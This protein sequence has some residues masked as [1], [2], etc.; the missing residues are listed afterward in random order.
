VGTASAEKEPDT[1]NEQDT[2]A[3]HHPLPGFLDLYPQMLPIRD[4]VKLPR[5][6]AGRLRDYKPKLLR[7]E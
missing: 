6:I 3:W 2:P 4:G 5:V 7:G 1:A